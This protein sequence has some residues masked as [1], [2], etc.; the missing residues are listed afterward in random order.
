MNVLP[1]CVCVCVFACVYA[2]VCSSMQNTPYPPPAMLMCICISE[3]G[4]L[5]I[6]PIPTSH[7]SLGYRFPCEQSC[8]L[9]GKAL[10][11]YV[12]SCLFAQ[13]IQTAPLLPAAPSCVPQSLALLLPTTACPGT[14]APSRPHS[15]AAPKLEG[16]EGKPRVFLIS[17]CPQI[18]PVSL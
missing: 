6:S 8:S 7:S 5:P 15:S 9:M 18:V 13:P 14:P 1:V 3:T 12:L 4:F 2:C 10:A 11:F 17:S 16:E